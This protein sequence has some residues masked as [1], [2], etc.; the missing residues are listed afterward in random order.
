MEISIPGAFL[1]MGSMRPQGWAA[2]DCSDGQHGTRGMRCSGTQGRD[3]R[4]L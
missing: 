2:W 4:G 3:A 1:H